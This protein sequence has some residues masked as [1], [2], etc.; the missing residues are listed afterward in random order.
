MGEYGGVQRENTIL[1]E[2]TVGKAMSENFGNNCWGCV[3]GNI[4]SKKWRPEKLRSTQA[5]GKYMDRPMMLGNAVEGGCQ[6]RMSAIVH[7][8]IF[9]N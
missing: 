6:E 8:L 7:F 3:V 5:V 2:I 4:K 9:N 1:V